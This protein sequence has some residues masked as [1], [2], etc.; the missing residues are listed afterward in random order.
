ML[1]IIITAWQIIK[2]YPI[3]IISYLLYFK[4]FISSS[5]QQLEYE[6]IV[7]QNGGKWPY[8]AR[9]WEG[10]LVVAIAI[11][12]IIVSSMNAIIRKSKAFYLLSILLIIIPLII[13]HY[14]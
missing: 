5:I 7:R 8:G 13:Y 3:S 14:L 2:K 11:I 10:V 9:E 4:I 12:L 6:R 1:P